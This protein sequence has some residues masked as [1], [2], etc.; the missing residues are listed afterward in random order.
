I[1]AIISFFFLITTSMAYPVDYV[2]ESGY[3]YL[4]PNPPDDV[5]QLSWWELSLRD[6]IIFS[7]V[8]VSPALTYP[9][10]LF[11]LVKVLLYSGYR[12]ITDKTVLDNRMCL[13]IYSRI[14]G[15]P[16]TTA[17]ILSKDLNMN[18]GTVRYH[19]AV[20]KFTRKITSMSNP[21]F[22]AF[23]ENHES[24]S[25]LE[26]KLLAHLENETKVKI[27]QYLQQSPDSSRQGIADHLCLS[28]PA[29]TWHMNQLMDD[30]IIVTIRDGKYIRHSLDPKAITVL[31]KYLPDMT[32]AD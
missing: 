13:E 27:F 11:F 10:E 17:P 29:V 16:G 9:L 15:H 7:L 6:I 28:G 3:P 31:E 26:R 8:A 30:F 12:H 24:Q 1:L 2:V 25:I 19:L 21:G 20:L 5:K 23:F 22:I 18:L 14:R 4:I 32:H